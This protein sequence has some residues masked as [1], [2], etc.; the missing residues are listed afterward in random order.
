ML[1]KPAGI[2]SHDLVDMVRRAAKQRQVGHT[3]TLDPMATGLMAIL[4]GSATR[5]EPYL[6]GLDKTYSG[7]V[8]LG[9]VTDTDDV[10]G[11]ALERR[12]GPWPDRETVRQALARHEG[13]SDQSPPIFSAI[14]V[15]GRP[16]HRA[17]R[18]GQTVELRPRRVTAH[19]LELV[20]YAPPR[21]AFVAEVSSGYYI[22]SLAR[23]LG[24]DLGLGGTL[25]ALRRERV[26]PWAVTRAADPAE[27]PR[28]SDDDWRAGLLPLAAI[29]PH[30]PALELGPQE[31]W[32][33]GQGQT[34]PVGA[35]K[36]IPAEADYG[37]ISISKT[38]A[39]PDSQYKI[40]DSEGRFLG[41]GQMKEEASLGGPQPPRGPFLRPLR[42]F[43]PGASAAE[44]P[45][46]KE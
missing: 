11:Q 35:A 45:D 18:A 36:R 30:W 28:W 10:T 37:P 46:G 19:R 1:D 25:A 4:L 44:S 9:L 20:E 40:L 38:L 6:V 23:D 14:K 29:L 26:G 39:T 41:L 22:R 32:R 8:E 7:Q 15:G 2:T 3:G 33:F 42:V 16:A 12:E 21:L 31:A 43:N 34:I 24:A 5:L 27:L 13:E 17:A